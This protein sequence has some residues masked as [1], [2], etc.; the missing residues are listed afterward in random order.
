MPLLVEWPSPCPT[1]CYSWWPVACLAPINI[2]SVGV[3]LCLPALYEQLS[4]T[5]YAN[6][7]QATVGKASSQCHLHLWATD[8]LAPMH[9]TPAL[10]WCRAH[11]ADPA[12]L[13]TGFEAR[14]FIW[15]APLALALQC[16]FVPL[17]KPGEVARQ[18]QYFT[19]YTID[20][21]EAV[22]P[23]NGGVLYY[24]MIREYSICMH[25]DAGR[26]WGTLCM[27]AHRQ[28]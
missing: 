13:N 15:G 11:S 5:T 20:L 23:D 16:S 17:R 1:P 26:V 22:L 7:L 14:G 21:C 4:C 24:V 6:C 9:L 3:L 18:A 28:A 8:G 19:S 10:C 12:C 2:G 27:L 25:V